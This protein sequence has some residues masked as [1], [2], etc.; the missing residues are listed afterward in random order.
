MS[1]L[2]VLKNELKH[3]NIHQ[4]QQQQ[5]SKSALLHLVAGTAFVYSLH[6]VFNQIR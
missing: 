2:F 5:Q 3:H 1:V 6:F 4:Q